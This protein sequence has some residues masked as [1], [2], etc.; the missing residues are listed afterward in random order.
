MG[1]SP[2]PTRPPY[3][4]LVRVIGQQARELNPKASWDE[5][6]RE[7]ETLWGSYVTGLPWPEVAGK[8]KAA[9]EDAEPRL[10]KD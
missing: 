9:W 8:I 10:Q 5:L 7:L 4:A 6:S 3:S 1:E 2:S